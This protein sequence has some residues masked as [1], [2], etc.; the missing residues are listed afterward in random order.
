MAIFTA[1]TVLTG[2]KGV[3]NSISAV[4]PFLVTSAVGIS[5]APFSSYR[6]SRIPMSLFR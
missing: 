6:H 2:I 4:V 3:I 1:L 5:I